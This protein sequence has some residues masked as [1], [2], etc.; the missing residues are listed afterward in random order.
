M[1]LRLTA[2][3]EQVLL[4]DHVEQLNQLSDLDPAMVARDADNGSSE[5]DDGPTQ[6]YTFS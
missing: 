6:S 1:L 5:R 4:V 2:T 3:N